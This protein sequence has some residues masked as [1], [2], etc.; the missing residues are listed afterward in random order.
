M[1]DPVPLGGSAAADAS[2]TANP[3]AAALDNPQPA[4]NMAQ[5]G[6]LAPEL[7]R[8][9][10]PPFP[11]GGP[12]KPLGNT[13]GIDGTQKCYYLN[14][15]GQ[16]VGLEMGNRHGKNSMIG[17]YGPA[18]GFLEANWP[19]WSAPQYEGRGKD[20]VLVKESE[21]IGFDQAEASRAHIEECLRLGIFDPAGRM[22][23]R[24]AHRMGHSAGMV[25]HCGDKLLFSRL[26]SD[27][28]VRDWHWTD[29]GL[30][31]GYVY[32]A[33]SPIPRP[34]HEAEGV[35]AG[36]KLLK[37]LATWN[38]KRELLDPRFALGAIGAGM[39]G[40]WL[41]WRP[42]VWVTGGRGTGK[43][44]LNGKDG[45]LHQVFGEG[46]FRT[47]DTSAA[48]LRQ[49]LK[50]STVPVMIDEAESEDDNRRIL[51]VVKLARIASSG[52]NLTRGGNDHQAHEFT[53]QSTFWFSSIIIPPLQ[54][55][56]RSRL[57]ILELKPLRDDA[58]KMNLRKHGLGELGKRLHRR[59][60]DAL[61][62]IEETADRFRA[63]LQAVGHDA[64]A[65]DQF[66]T[67]LACA[68]ALL[69]D[70]DTADGLPPDEELNT[71]AQ[72]CRPERIAEVS[73]AQSDELA[74]LYHLASS[75]AQSR[76][77]EE[78]ET[79]GTWIG[80]AVHHAAVPLLDR[81]TASSADENAGKRLEQLGLKLVNPLYRREERDLA[82]KLVKAGRWGA[83]NFHA[84][85]PGYLAVAWSHEALGDVF[86]GTKW[87]GGGWRQILARC[88]GAIDGVKVSLARMKYNTVLVPLHVLFADDDDDRRED[89]TL[90][91]AS[92]KA[93]VAKWIAEQIEGGE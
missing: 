40:G 77:G 73:A 27:G 14:F 56:D 22:R 72:L 37:L 10:R 45:L 52:D 59:M 38:W 2:A 58:P 69:E 64:R 47:A 30:L 21:I 65:C 78:R 70:W 86:K 36:E 48:G 89:R 15:N 82:G 53:L 41:G 61:P 87:Q 25:L 19:Q 90:P 1:S 51:D 32:T 43:S 85:E 34:A 50:N 79:I 16:L 8:W 71:W 6:D 54:A 93:A 31:D 29:P 33:A 83:Q 88:E 20:R 17:L 13:Q 60:I 80:R 23:G 68:D 57:A 44:T 7:D 5:P 9:E 67:L 24:G 81:A 3:I 63:A 62:R 76:G 55:S 39:I 46:V 75:P 18:S 91:D 49:S 84:G 11:R 26:K 92:S 35:G 4:P 66:G 12:V 28:T 74:C 42:N